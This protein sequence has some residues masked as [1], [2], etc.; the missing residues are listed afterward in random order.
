MVEIIVFFVLL[1][2]ALKRPGLRKLA[3]S[4]TAFAASALAICLSEPFRDVI[5]SALRSEPHGSF[6]SRAIGVGVLFFLAVLASVAWEERP[7]RK[8]EVAN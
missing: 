1:A 4:F 8:R 6:L 2:C 5:F 7:R 3:P